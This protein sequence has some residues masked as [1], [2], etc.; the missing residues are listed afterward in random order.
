MINLLSITTN[1]VIKRAITTT[2]LLQNNTKC[3]QE[4]AVITAGDFRNRLALHM[5]R[6]GHGAFSGP[7]KCYQNAYRFLL[8]AVRSCARLMSWKA[9][10]AASS[11]PRF[12]RHAL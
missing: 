2:E 10:L 8:F 4:F 7:R 12:S 1:S 9:I 11:R 3:Y 6:R 5:I